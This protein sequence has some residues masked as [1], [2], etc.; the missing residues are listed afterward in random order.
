MAT[1]ENLY[2]GDGTIVDRPF[3]FPYL[4]E[5]DIKVSLGGVITTN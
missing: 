2:T 4:A 5:T 3:T 1:I